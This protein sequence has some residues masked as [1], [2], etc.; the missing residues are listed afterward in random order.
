MDKIEYEVASAEVNFYYPAGAPGDTP[1][2]GG[3]NKLLQYLS[4]GYE[5]YNTA[6]VASESYG[7][8]LYILRKKV[9]SEDMAIKENL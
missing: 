4:K 6:V 7:G 1:S 3:A 2:S 9:K 5:I 8:V